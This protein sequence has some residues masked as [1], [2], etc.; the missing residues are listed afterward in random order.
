MHDRP[1]LGLLL[2]AAM[3][4]GLA[5]LIVVLARG[6]LVQVDRA[7][8]E[9]ALTLARTVVRAIEGLVRHGPD[10]EGRAWGILDE[11]ARDPEVCS[12]GIV[13][14]GGETLVSRGDPVPLVP[15]LPGSEEVRTEPGRLVAS[16]PLEIRP[17]CLA[18]DGC[19]C[20]TGGCP[21][22]EAGEWSV[23]AGRYQLVLV[24]DRAGAERVR[25]PVFAVAALGVLLLA[26]LLAVSTLLSRSL[27]ARE[28]LARDVAI[29]QQRRRDLESLSLLA[30]G[31]AH[32][33]R[34]PLGAI[35]GWAQM[36]HEQSADDASRD[37]AALML[38]DLD[39]IAERVEEFLGFAR[40]RH[41]EPRPVDLGVLAR[42]TAALLQPDAE[43]AGIALSVAA[44]EPP[45]V[46]A[47][48]AAQLKEVLLNLT[49]NALD[50]CDRGGH[51]AI[52]VGP[53]REG[54]TVTVTDD[55]HGIRPEDRSRLFE[56][57]FTTK[58]RGSGL[59]LAISRRIA[60]DHCA[61]LTV[62]NAPVRGAVARL[63]FPPGGLEGAP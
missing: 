50:A 48:D 45:V 42:G 38:G 7:A 31:L 23:P 13:A 17:G 15:S 43:S 39:R 40:K 51:V 58:Q 21:C 30:A 41:V 18:T 44:P 52:E 11:V 37:R 26:A 3:T 47:G 14:L 62:E 28:R 29:E 27:A 25:F 34:N 55:G 54:A 9:R 36:L 2:Q 24:L 1:H 61:V 35:R 20:G 10:Q 19:R 22:G 5:L 63:V 57:Y 8:E 56:P 6:V 16:I 4:V 12:V 32:E 49:L 60:E 53:G 33:I 46:I 59:G